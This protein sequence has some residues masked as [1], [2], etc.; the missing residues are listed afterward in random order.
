MVDSNQIDDGG[1]AFPGKRN[2]QVGMVSDYG[3]SD[4]D[5]PTFAEVEHPGMS[6]R[7]YFAAQALAGICANTA[8]NDTFHS[9]VSAPSA[10]AAYSMADAMIAARKAGAA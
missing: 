10:H 9:S 6:L 3:F 1:L 8:W 4:D 2:Q 7:D 5:S